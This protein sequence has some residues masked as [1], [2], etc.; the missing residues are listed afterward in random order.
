MERGLR[1]LWGET[2]EGSRKHYGPDRRGNL[3]VAVIGL[4]LL[5]GSLS[6]QAQSP[7]EK[8]GQREQQPGAYLFVIDHSGSMT[9]KGESG[10][11]RWEEIQQNL[12]EV[13]DKV[14]LET[15][16][17]ILV[18]DS[19]LWDPLSLQI[20]NERD[21]EAL[22]ERIR[23]AWKKPGG[24]TAYYHALVTACQKAERMSRDTPLRYITIMAFSDGKDTASGPRAEQKFNQLQGR[25]R[26][27]NANCKVIEI[28]DTEKTPAPW[29]PIRLVGTRAV[30]ENPSLP[31]ED[32]PTVRMCIDY[33][34]SMEGEL[35]G[36]PL[37][38]RFDPKGGP[39]QAH[40]E[41]TYRL[42]QGTMEVQLVVD[43]PDELKATEAYRGKLKIDYPD[44]PGY[45]VVAEG[46]DEVA[47]HFKESDEPP[48]IEVVA[49][50]TGG[51]E[52]GGAF[53]VGKEILFK[54]ST[55]P[56]AEVT[57]NF[58]DDNSKTGHTVHYA[59]QG[60]NTADGKRIPYSV[61]VRAEEDPRIGPS[62]KTFDVSVV[63]AGVGISPLE[64][65]VYAG[66]PHKFTCTGRGP[67][68]DYRWIIDDT[69]YDGAGAD[70][71]GIV[72]AFSTAREDHT[73]RVVASVEGLNAVVQSPEVR[74]AVGPPPKLTLAFPADPSRH[75]FGENIDCLAQVAGPVERVRWTVRRAGE[76]A[77]V[78][79]ATQGVH[80]RDGTEES[81]YQLTLPERLAAHEDP[82]K[83]S[84]FTLTAS[85][86]FG[87]E[88]TAAISELPENLRRGIRPSETVKLLLTPLGRALK[89]VS[90]DE[91]DWFFDTDN[92]TRQ[93]Q[94]RAQVAGADVREVD[95]RLVRT[96]GEGEEAIARTTAGVADRAEG[97]FA[98]WSFTF[99]EEHLQ[100]GRVR[101]PVRVVA[102][103]VLPEGTPTA[104]PSDSMQARI[105]YDPNIP[106][107][108]SG[109]VH[110]NFTEQTEAPVEFHVRWGQPVGEVQWQFGDAKAIVRKGRRI[111]HTFEKCGQ[112]SVKATVAGRDATE[113]ADSASIDITFVKPQA[114]PVLR[115]NGKEVSEVEAGSTVTLDDKSTGDV[116]ER[117]WSIYRLKPGTDEVAETICEDDSR[118][119]VTLET[120]GAYRIELRVVGPPRREG[121]RAED[122]E[123]MEFGVTEP[124]RWFLFFLATALGLLGF[125]CLWYVFSGNEPRQWRLKHGENEDKIVL[126]RSV[127][128]YWSSIRKR[129]T[130][131]MA[132]LFS[133]SDY[134]RSGGGMNTDLIL[135]RINRGR[136]RVDGNLRPS[137]EG[138][139]TVTWEEIK[140]TEKEK[141]YRLEDAGAPPEERY[142]E[143]YFCLVKD[144]RTVKR[145]VFARAAAVVG[146]AAWIG[147]AYGIFC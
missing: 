1:K 11:S 143:V 120:V 50:R 69:E 88:V 74:V 47:L 82:T 53:P 133:L 13:V 27:L 76:D 71:T 145:D 29:L 84:E 61:T 78:S 48:P 62:R 57:W 8:L 56:G 130:I 107:E 20:N 89:I 43:N 79:K 121:Q 75:V 140:S 102:E 94:F 9:T 32:R 147:M 129:A 83:V 38:V 73:L 116:I 24:K 42:K 35:R 99:D 63:D 101:E 114:K 67:L 2:A 19:E 64:S 17:W 26:T 80:E 15:E 6:A 112:Y 119:S 70:G 109:P 115:H 54:V 5:L 95:W 18:F 118:R 44:V 59:Y 52:P 23:T 28:Y 60:E 103:A 37:K 104:P 40:V 113:H 108:V 105:G 4:L 41:G 135:T 110:A 128:D 87:D 100:T 14:P 123:S 30:L 139:M 3:G 31:E 134:W 21:R 127:A 55:T 39:V 86:E 77:V 96:E 90:P 136:G 72:H 34:D 85:A 93:V 138:E 131:P 117:L 137:S 146:L 66:I 106:L 81:R 16:I 126:S 125:G 122:V 144:M 10:R 12:V 91:T 33:W 51:A 45:Q 68:T 142:R 111:T 46:G 25:L 98:S 7:C 132:E 92:F 49:P 58:G 65:P 141:T 22:K 124:A 36:K 97:R